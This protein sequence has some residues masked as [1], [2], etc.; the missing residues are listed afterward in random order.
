MKD[1]EQQGNLDGHSFKI[2]NCRYVLKVIEKNK[3][4]HIAQRVL[5]G[6]FFY[7]G[8][9][10]V[11]D[12]GNE[13]R[14]IVDPA[15]RMSDYTDKGEYRKEVYDVLVENGLVPKDTIFLGSF[16]PN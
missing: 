6:D 14:I 4:E 9:K 7:C 5:N 10:F 2:L 3:G 15:R 12:K 16:T 1:L 11:S 13:D 8:V